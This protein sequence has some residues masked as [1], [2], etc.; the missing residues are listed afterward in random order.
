MKTE[1]TFCIQD[2][3]RSSQQHE[4]RTVFEAEENDMDIDG[5]ATAHT[6]PVEGV[7]RS[8]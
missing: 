1:T 7:F 4:H 3:A 6:G 8:L 5:I 2:V